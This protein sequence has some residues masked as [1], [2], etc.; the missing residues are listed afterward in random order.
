MPAKPLILVTNDDGVHAPGIRLLAKA[1]Q[2]VGR[3]VIIAPE[4]D[5]SG[6]SHSLTFDRPL[7]VRQLEEDVYTMDGTPTDCVS[8]GIE[9]ILPEKPGLVISGINP[10]GNLG[11][12]VS[13][14][15]TVSAA[16]EGTMLGA[17]SLAVSL[18]GEPPFLFET[19]AAFAARLATAIWERGLPRDTLLN[20]NVPNLPPAR[21]VGVRFTRQGH[22]VYENAIKETFDPWGRKHYWIGGG[23]PSWDRDPDTDSTAVLI[24]RHI[25][26]TPIH[27]DLTNHEALAD[28]R[29]SWKID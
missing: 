10:G 7:R 13:Y 22:R 19:A 20:V 28:M 23:T 27:L 25:S 5:N 16:I 4:R 9:K 12:D 29:K 14:S 17:P 3:P 24:D 11:D 1:M 26:V 8:I 6:A 18:V 21:L 15:G 2:E